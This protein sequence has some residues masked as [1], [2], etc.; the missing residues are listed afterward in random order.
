MK[1][2]I[3][4]LEN[5]KD[6]KVQAEI[7]INALAKVISDSGL[8]D[9]NEINSSKILQP[10][11]NNLKRSLVNYFIELDDSGE[12]DQDYIYVYSIGDN[13]EG[14]QVQEDEDGKRDVNLFSFEIDSIDILKKGTED[15]MIEFGKLWGSDIESGVLQGWEEGWTDY[16][17]IKSTEDSL[18]NYR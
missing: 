11:I 2:Y 3:P 8:V 13:D 14:I 5:W 1:Q 7:N 9:P 18:M 4:L 16:Y 12:I 10:T 15:E 17:Q 6:W